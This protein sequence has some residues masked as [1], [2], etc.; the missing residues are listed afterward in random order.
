MSS[1]P[2]FSPRRT[3]WQ[4]PLRGPAFAHATRLWD[5]AETVRA[6]ARHVAGPVCVGAALT[7]L[8]AQD[9]DFW[10]NMQRYARFALTT[11]VGMFYTVAKP[12]YDLLRCERPAR[13]AGYARAHLPPPPARLLQQAQDGHSACGGHL[14]ADQAGDVDHQRHAGP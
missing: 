6:L 11:S 13:Q 9:P 7:R 1:S 14:R 3:T 2:I 8:R 10:V 5:L 4:W 12:L